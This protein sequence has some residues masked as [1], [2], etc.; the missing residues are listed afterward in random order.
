MNMTASPYER[1]IRLLHILSEAATA[2]LFAIE[3]PVLRY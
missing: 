2:S 1:L 3:A